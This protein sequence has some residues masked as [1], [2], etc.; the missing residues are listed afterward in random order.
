MSIFA[1][2]LKVN[3]VVVDAVLQ[4]EH[5][6]VSIARGHGMIGGKDLPAAFALDLRLDDGR[7]LKVHPKQNFRLKQSGQQSDPVAIVDVI[8][9][10][11]AH[12]L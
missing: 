3:D 5:R 4:T 7:V 1:R 12:S 9:R 2:D 11:R 6:V 8:E 10:D